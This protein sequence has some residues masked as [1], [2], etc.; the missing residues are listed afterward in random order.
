MNIMELILD[1]HV[2]ECLQI[3]KA[4]HVINKLKWKAIQQSSFTSVWTVM[5]TFVSCPVQNAC[6]ASKLYRP[7]Q[8]QEQSIK[9]FE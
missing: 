8:Q 2:I 6:G 9:T 7:N 1:N 5:S 3:L 4:K